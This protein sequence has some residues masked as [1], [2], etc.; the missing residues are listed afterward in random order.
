M[1]YDGEG[2]ETHGKSQKGYDPFSDELTPLAVRHKRR[3]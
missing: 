3:K 2:F 1:K